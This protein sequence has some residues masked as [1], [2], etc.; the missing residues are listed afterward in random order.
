[1]IRQ[2]LGITTK[3]PNEITDVV[4]RVQYQFL[5]QNG[6]EIIAMPARMVFAG[7][8]VDGKTCVAKRDA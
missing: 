6:Q 8:T 4:K 5:L 3:E 2:F 7:L 1:M